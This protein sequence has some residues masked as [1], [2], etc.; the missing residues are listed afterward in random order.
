[1]NR[2]LTLLIPISFALIVGACSSVDEEPPEEE[3]EP[4][5]R[6]LAQ[7]RGLMFG[8]AADAPQINAN[9]QYRVTLAREFG[10]LTP[11]NELKFGPLRPSRVTFSW[12]NADALVTFA[13]NS[14]MKVRGH[15]LVWHQQNPFWLTSGSFTRAQ[16]MS[17]LEEHIKAVVGRYRGRIGKWDVVNEGIAD[18]GSMRQSLWFERIG[19][20]YIEL[21][22][23]WAHE[24]DPDA[25]LYYND[26]SAEG[27]GAKSN[28]VFNLVSDLKNRGVP[29]HGVGMQ[30]H[31]S[32]DFFPGAADV[33]GNMQRLAAAGFLVDITEMDV[34]ILLPASSGELAVQGEIYR[35]M[36]DVCL[37]APNCMS[38]TVWGVTDAHSWIPG[39]FP[40][41]GAGLLFDENYATKLAYSRIRD[42]LSGLN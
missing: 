12:D 16:L 19:P 11:E 14:G 5:L 42:L 28:A 22:F 20:E 21:A 3:G 17:I 41:F 24:A 34:R 13:E 4:A 25:L 18:N 23:Q 27:S 32:T 1:M 9:P 29:I 39:F 38:F 26:Y 31:V 10:A 6:D 7:A 33:A 37:D 30:M 8:A 35:T 15:T 40:G 36:V 2:L